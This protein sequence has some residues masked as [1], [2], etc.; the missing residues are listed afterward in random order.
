MD[1]TSKRVPAL[2]HGL[3]GVL[4]PLLILKWNKSAHI[5]NRKWR[6]YY[7]HF[8]QRS[9]LF[10]VALD[11]MTHFQLS[12]SWRRIDLPMWS[13]ALSSWM[14][15]HVPTKRFEKINT[16]FSVAGRNFL[17][18]RPWSRRS[19]PRGWSPAFSKTK[20][21]TWTKCHTTQSELG[22]KPDK[23]GTKTHSTQKAEPPPL[24]N[25]NLPLVLIL[26][27]C[28]LV[29]PL[30]GP[31]KFVP[32]QQH[33]CSTCG[34]TLQALHPFNPSTPPLPESTF[35]VAGLRGDQPLVYAAPPVGVVWPGSMSP[36]RAS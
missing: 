23:N 28:L 32:G 16:L 14:H 12:A 22:S 11:T 10:Q 9:K 36:K 2:L 15:N 6:R 25:N 29:L 30:L 20:S 33:S 8:Q 27:K 34:Y 24:F 5:N 7:Q 4:G 35:H 18:S 1:P 26:A 17:S 31:G 3:K 13:P 19:L 21:S